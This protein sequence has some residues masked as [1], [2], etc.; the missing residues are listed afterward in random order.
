MYVLKAKTLD[1]N[2]IPSEF[3]DCI[4]NSVNFVSRWLSVIN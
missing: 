1:S 3:Y 2:E 4:Y